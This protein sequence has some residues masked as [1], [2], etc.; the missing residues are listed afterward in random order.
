VGRGGCVACHSGPFLSDQRFHN[1]GLVP[2]I[3]QQFILDAHDRGAA[4][5]IATLIMDPLNSSGPFSDGADTRIPSAVTSAM[6][7][8]FR[9]PMLRCVNMRPS[10]M[11]TGQFQSLEAVVAFFNRGG[12][13]A[14]GGYPGM[15]EIHALELSARDQGDLTEFLR[16]LDG[17]GP[18]TDLRALPKM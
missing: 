16:T 12:D 18:P 8:A 5:G 14:G 13:A 10:W 2:A 1:V 11:H 6:E 7:G 3:V 9:T 15:S 17:P 4:V